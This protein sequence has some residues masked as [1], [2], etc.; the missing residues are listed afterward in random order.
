MIKLLLLT[1]FLGSGKTTLM[2]NILARYSEEKVGI[3]INEFGETGVD[4]SL[5]A[6]NGVKMDELNNGSI[7]CA[8]IKA[9]FLQSLIDMSKR[10]ISYLFIEPSGIADPSEMSQILEIIAPK[11]DKGYDYR[12]VVCVIDA[13]TFPK[14]SKVLPALTRQVEYCGAAIINKSDLVD[15]SRLEEITSLINDINPDCEIIVT[16]YCQFD[17]RALTSRLSPVDIAAKYS[18]NTPEMR[19]CSYVLKPQG[20]VPID[21]LREFVETLLPHAYRIKGFLPSDSGIIVVSAVGG[22]VNI[23]HWAGDAPVY[24]L[25]VISSVGIS[26][27]SRITDALGDELK[28]ILRL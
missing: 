14:L 22:V 15:G 4:G 13:E 17:A 25:V 8:C 11:L 18:T 28:E 7:F 3:I 10:D 9:N 21:M 20:N 27:I 26:I 12:G 24:G 5:L 23:G 16:S 6:R 19:P 1:G 2:T